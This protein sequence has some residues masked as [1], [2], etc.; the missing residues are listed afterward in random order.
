VDRKSIASTEACRTLLLPFTYGFLRFLLFLPFLIL[1]GTKKKEKN[2]FL[3]LGGR[4]ERR[5]NV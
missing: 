2:V 3:S 1:E 5:T 4:I